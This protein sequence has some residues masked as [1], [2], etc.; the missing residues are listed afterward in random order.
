MNKKLLAS[1]MGVIALLVLGFVVYSMTRSQN[2]TDST[3][4]TSPSQ[5]KTA[6][7]PG[8]SQIDST[9][10]SATITYTDEGFS[11]SALKV[12]AGTTIRV[13]N[14]ASD[15]LEFSSDNHPTHLKNS[16]LNMDVLA[17]GE[18]GTFTVTRTGE[19]GFH[20]HLNAANEGSLTVTE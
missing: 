8:T 18:S 4:S 2:S 3:Q 6:E 15:A 1:V 7:T 12:K 19:Y 13:V 14:N 17:A 9:A 5:T 20:D 10:E 11:P 16:E